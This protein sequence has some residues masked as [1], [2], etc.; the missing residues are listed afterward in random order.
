MMEALR[1]RVNTWIR[2][3]VAAFLLWAAAVPLCTWLVAR[4]FVD[5]FDRQAIVLGRI[6]GK[7]DREVENESSDEARLAA[8]EYRDRELARRIQGIEEK[9]WQTASKSTATAKPTGR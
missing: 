5:F 8:S 4:V 1:R 6:E 7:I 2:I 9:L 3:C